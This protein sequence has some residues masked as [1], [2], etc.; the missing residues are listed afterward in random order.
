MITLT[1]LHSRKQI[2]VSP[3]TT[4]L[5]AAQQL[6]LE[7]TALCGGAG[8]CGQCRILLRAG[9][10][11]IT[12]NDRENLTPEEIDQGYR[13]AC[14]A[15][16]AGDCT[17]EIPG[18]QAA[19]ISPILA[20]GHGRPI[21][22]D[23][24]VQ[25]V[26]VELAPPTLKSG[27]SDLEV[28]MAALPE[29]TQPPPLR[30]LQRLPELLRAENWRGH[31]ILLDGRLIDFHPGAQ[32]RPL[33]GV[34]VDLGTTTVVAKLID[35]ESGLLLATAA[36]LNRQRRYGEDVIT[37]THH[38][39][40][41]G[42]GILHDLI[43]A[44]LNEMIEELRSDACHAAKV[45]WLDEPHSAPPGPLSRS[46]PD[47]SPG[48][49]AGVLPDPPSGPLSTSLSGPLS[50]SR[51]LPI[52]PEDIYR[53]VVAGNSVMEHLLLGLPP[54]QLAEMPYIP[55]ARHLPPL[56]AEEIGLKAHPE[57]VLQALPLL[58]KFVGGDTTAVL[59]TLADR[60]D[61]TWLAVD[62]GTNGEIL[63]CHQ[64]KIWTTS[65]AAGPAFEGAHIAAGMR[66]A[67]GAIERVWWRPKAA[68][69]APGQDVLP[70]ASGGRLEI[71]VIGGGEAIGICGSGLI[72]AA[73]ALLEAGALDET[74]RLDASHPLVSRQSSASAAQ[75]AAGVWLTQKD[76][77]EIQ[78]AKSAIATA[79][80]LL[81]HS[82]GL[83]AEDLQHVYL[84][85]AFGQY[86][87]PDAALRIGLLPPVALEKIKFIGN[88]ACAGAEMVVA[89]REESRRLES[90]LPHVEYIEVAA[91]AQFQD[92]FA[93]NLLF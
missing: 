69:G 24:A 11:D 14:S 39:N 61:E 41:H 86:I 37:R 66:A 60:L 15:E 91:A 72:D 46:L 87:R 29:G 70:D 9:E 28:L 3:G 93:E 58:G 75:L 40:E 54:R 38:A 71:Q 84:A 6:D 30:L 42:V 20:A 65:A 13:L 51:L 73:A 23:P 83:A 63:L 88:A 8:L 31:A 62:I 67:E 68:A 12:A 25:R 78:L 77:R 82:A 90:L 4:I 79:I 33:L 45:A 5:D 36:E 34:A 19:H 1:F 32:R 74:G 76:I 52:Q 2:A 92:I 59:L 64:G 22:P 55:A 21:T 17:I 57:A 35:L 85:G 48:S 50:A 44:Q 16:P 27:P 7:I 80:A 10:L 43:I 53:I 47:P 56:R 81:L 26:P 49:L 89:S 18:A